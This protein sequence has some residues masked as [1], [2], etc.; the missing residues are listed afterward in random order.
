MS[1]ARAPEVTLIG[2]TLLRKQQ[3]EQPG[4]TEA[5]RAGDKLSSLSAIEQYTNQ[6]S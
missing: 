1:A 6:L 3:P 5:E 2:A 4:Q